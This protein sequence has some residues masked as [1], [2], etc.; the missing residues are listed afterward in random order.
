M[1]AKVTLIAVG[2]LKEPYWREAADEY[3]KRLR[4]YATMQVVEV[5][6]RDVTRNEAEAMAAEGADVLRALQTAGS[7]HC[8]ALDV[9]GRQL[10]SEGLAEWL[11]ANDL[12]GT[13]ALTFAIGGAAGLA[14]DVLARADER[15]SLGPMT[16]PHQMA[17]V[18]LLEQLYRA[19]RIMRGEPYHR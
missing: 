7:S 5:S 15:L 4:P 16:L 12:S 1:P 13:S 8:V 3:L 6:D 19:F 17:R 2:R 11:A 14:S 9:G 18:V 10:S